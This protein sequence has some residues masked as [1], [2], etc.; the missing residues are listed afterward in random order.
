MNFEQLL[1]NFEKLLQNEEK[2]INTPSLQIKGNVLSFKDYFIQIS[3]ISQVSIAPV[4]KQPYPILAFVLIVFGLMLFTVDSSFGV[5][6][7]MLLA[8]YGG[9][10]LYKV[11][12]RNANR[13]DNLTI[14]LNSGSVFRFNFKNR[15]FLDEVM[16]V[17]QS[18]ANN[19]NSNV[20]IDFQNSVVTMGDQNRVVVEKL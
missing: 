12:T 1:N 11:H 16:E 18:C 9:Y 13:G 17:L 15:E 20:I 10:I 8:G 3:N 19:R 14:G 7:G 2:A 5:M 6:L 4:A